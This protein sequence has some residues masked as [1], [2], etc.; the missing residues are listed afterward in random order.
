M[1]I[2]GSENITN[3]FKAQGSNKKGYPGSFIFTARVNNVILNEDDNGWADN[4]EYASIGYI[5]FS[6]PTINN[7][8]ATNLAKPLFPNQKYYPVLNEMVYIIGIPS[9]GVNENPTLVEFYYFQAVNVWNSNHHN[10]LPDEIFTYQQPESQQ[11]DYPT[12]GLGAVRRVSDESTEINLGKTFFERPNIRTLQPY[13]GDYILEGRWGNSIRFGSTVADTTP[14]NTWSDSGLNG[15]PI[16]IIRNGQYENDQD[17]WVPIVENINQDSG[18]IYLTSTQKINLTPSLSVNASGSTYNSYPTKTKPKAIN[19]YIEPQV[20]IN[21]NRLVFNTNKDHLLLSSIKSVGLNAVESV[22]IDTPKTII[23]SNEVYLGGKNA[24]E[25]VLKGDETI[26]ILVN[27]VD[28]L[29]ALYSVLSTLTGAIDPAA[30]AV[31]TYA[32]NSSTTLQTLTRIKTDLL[33]KTKS[34]ISKT[35]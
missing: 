5:N 17:P 34:N 1:S 26:K 2:E 3:Q 10:A 21:S 18:S 20:I 8:T 4:G 11:Q 14:K 27:L 9:L 28:E 16:V 19:E 22:N 15:D 31:G 7:A 30:K 23:Q 13:E 24:T 33:T 32:V 6:D 25:P 12:V 29:T 35:L